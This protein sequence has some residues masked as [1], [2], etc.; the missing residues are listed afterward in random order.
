MATG[1]ASF[2]GACAASQGVE[3]AGQSRIV[4]GAPRAQSTFDGE[5]RGTRRARDEA[6]DNIAPAVAS[7]DANARQRVAASGGPQPQAKRKKTNDSRGKAFRV[8]HLRTFGLKVAQRESSTGKVASAACRFCFHF[9]REPRDDASEADAAGKKSKS[10]NK[11]NI[12]KQFSPPWRTDAYTQHLKLAHKEKWAEYAYLDSAAKDAF[13]EGGSC[14]PYANTLD[15]HLEDSS[16]AMFFWISKD[17]VVKVLGEM[18]FDPL[19]SSENVES[20]LSIFKT[21]ND[22]ASGERE[23]KVTIKKVMAF[24]LVVDYVGAGLSFRQACAC[25]KATSDRTG[26]KKISGLREQDVCMLVRAVVGINLQKMSDLLRSKNCWSFSIAFD[27]ATVQCRSLLDVR[28]RLLVGGRIENLHLLAIPL[29]EAHTGINMAELVHSFMTVLCGE[30]WKDKLVG[31]CTDGARNMT[32][33]VNGA[34]THLAA[35]TLPGFFRVWCAA[36]QLDLVIQDAMSALCDETFYSNLTA[37]IGYLRRQQNLIASM[38]STCPKVASTRWLSLGRVCSWLSK[39][40]ARLF[41]YFAEKKPSCEPP[42]SW[43]AM[44][45][46]VEA[47]MEPVDICFKSLQGLTTIISEQDDLLQSLVSSL[48]AMLVMEGPLLPTNLIAKRT[49][50]DDNDLLG[51]ELATTRSNVTD[52]IADL[53]SFAMNCHQNLQPEEARS[54]EVGIGKLFLASVEKISAIRA[55]RNSSNDPSSQKLPRVLPHELAEV[56][57]RLFNGILFEQS[58]RLLCSGQSVDELE[59]EFRSFKAAVHSESTLLDSLR[60]RGTSIGFE[61]AWQPL[62]IRFAKLRQFCGGLA[63]VFPGTAT[64]ESDFSVL[65][66]EYDE[67]RSTLSELSLEGIMQCKQFKKVVELQ[68]NRPEET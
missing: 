51:A 23:R 11:T 34:V 60:K 30:S 44:L 25:L 38:R 16:G 64:V 29:R 46:A 1:P 37:L 6:E 7:S 40:R 45:L 14:V 13:F 50:G 42:L 18:L 53:G 57:P 26:L 12:V 4:R 2:V 5:R 32:G 33:R 56:A 52:F 35:G 22:G 54:I 58:Q 61:E 20:A 48:R 21:D 39:H 19:E 10:K 41:E 31:I 47:F 65:K 59:R 49:S 3:P 15:A 9:G 55:E 66:W 68:H 67:F 36:H 17:I 27:G 8:E 62:G 28:V 63:T 43:W 24:A